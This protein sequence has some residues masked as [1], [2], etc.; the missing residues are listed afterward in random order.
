MEEA[1]DKKPNTLIDLILN[2]YK[3]NG[4]EFNFSSYNRLVTNFL[5]VNF[6]ICCLLINCKIECNFI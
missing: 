4:K 5:K 3:Q 1:T 2:D 6:P